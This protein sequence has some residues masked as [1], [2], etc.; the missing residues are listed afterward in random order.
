MVRHWRGRAVCAAAV[1]AAGAGAWGFAGWITVPPP[2]IGPV[3]IVVLTASVVATLEE[4]VETS[5]RGTLI[6]AFVAPGDSVRAGQALLS[7]RDV[8]LQESFSTLES[9]IKDLRS[10]VAAEQA[11]RTERTQSASELLRIE[12]LRS[13]EESVRT[14]GE[15]NR[16]IQSLHDA[17][18]IARLEYERNV[19]E[20]EALKARLAE[21]QNAASVE[22]PA[23]A[24]AAQGPAA[25]GLERAERLLGRLEV[26]PETFEVRSPWDGPSSRSMSTRTTSQAGADRW[27]RSRATPRP[28]SRSRQGELRM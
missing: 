17:G 14:A 7:F 19:R 20:F 6:A 25:R 4:P 10:R 8:S 26:L 12:T 11:S 24:T 27:R 28:V 16:R 21:A 5:R 15:E 2:S 13:L 9:R 1:V 3:R 18:L 22:S 23:S